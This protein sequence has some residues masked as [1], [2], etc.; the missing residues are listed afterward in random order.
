V[1]VIF[2]AHRAASSMTSGALC[3]KTERE[4]EGAMGARPRKS[5]HECTTPKPGPGMPGAK[6]G[7]LQ[8]CM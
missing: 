4:G 1:E 8:A 2:E 5:I 6:G 7:G 3:R